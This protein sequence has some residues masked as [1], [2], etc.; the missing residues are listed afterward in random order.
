MVKNNNNM[1]YEDKITVQARRV[2]SISITLIK[3]LKTVQSVT[4]I[5]VCFNV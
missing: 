3:V 1:W 2:N 5:I 4:F